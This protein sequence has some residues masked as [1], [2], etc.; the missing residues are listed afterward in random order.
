MKREGKGIG[1]SIMNYEE[2]QIK[3]ER[4]IGIELE[5]CKELEGW[6][7]RGRTDLVYARVAMLMGKERAGSMNMG[8]TDSSENIVTDPEEVRETW[9]QSIEPLY[10]KSKKED[11]KF[12]EEVETD[13]KG[14]TVLKSKIL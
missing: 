4:L 13:D 14:P 3:Q 1:S 12:E 11:L 2:K 7:S 10:A 5:F 6:N 8:I 9:K